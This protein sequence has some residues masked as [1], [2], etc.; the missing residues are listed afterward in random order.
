MRIQCEASMGNTLGDGV[1]WREIPR[2]L[3]EEHT[4]LLKRMGR[5]RNLVLR[6]EHTGFCEQ[7]G[8]FFW[9]RGDG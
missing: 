9:R 2:I 6:R 1:D 7:V 5:E 3:G 4:G 8:F